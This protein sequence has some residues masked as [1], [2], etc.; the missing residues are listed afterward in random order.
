MRLSR[1]LTRLKRVG[2]VVMQRSL[3][4]RIVMMYAVYSSLTFGFLCVILG[5]VPAW[6]ALYN[7]EAI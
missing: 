2:D 6:A 3:K 5:S 4:H 1:G 7:N